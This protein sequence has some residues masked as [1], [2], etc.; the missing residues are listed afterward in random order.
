MRSVV[1]QI[2]NINNNVDLVLIDISTDCI[3][4][5]KTGKWVTIVYLIDDVKNNDVIRVE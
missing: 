5:C 1:D 3:D 4:Q 2:H